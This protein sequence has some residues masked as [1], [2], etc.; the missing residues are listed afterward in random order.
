MQRSS[1]Q[2][3]AIITEAKRAIEAHAEAIDEDNCRGIFTFRKIKGEIF[4]SIKI[5]EVCN[6]P[7]L[8]HEN[9]WEERCFFP[10]EPIT[11]NLTGEYIDLFNNNK[12]IKQMATWMIEEKK[13]V[14]IRPNNSRG[15][16]NSSN[17]NIGGQHTQVFQ[18]IKTSN[19]TYKN[20]EDEADKPQNNL[21]HHK[22]RYYT[23]NLEAN[24][25]TF[26][27][28]LHDYEES[29]DEYEDTEDEYEDESEDTTEDEDEEVVY[30]G[31]PKK[32]LWGKREDVRTIII[33]PKATCN[34]IGHQLLP[35]LKQRIERATGVTPIII[36]SYAKVKLGN[37]K[38]VESSR[39]IIVPL[40]LGRTRSYAEVHIVDTEAPFIIGAEFLR[41]HRDAISV[42][43]NYMI[44]NNHRIELI[45]LPSA[46]TALN[47]DVETHNLAQ[48]HKNIA[49]Q[50][51]WAR[52]QQ[53]EKQQQQ[54]HSVHEQPPQQQ[55]QS[56][57]K[58]TKQQQEKKQPVHEQLQQQLDQQQQ[59]EDQQLQQ[60]PKEQSVQEG[61]QHQA[62]QQNM[63]TVQ[64]KT[65][66]LQEKTAQN[67]SKNNTQ[68]PNID[69]TQ[70]DLKT[71]RNKTEIKIK[72]CDEHNTT[73]PVD[74]TSRTHPS[75][76]KNNPRIEAPR[77]KFLTADNLDKIKYHHKIRTNIEIGNCDESKL[78][79]E[80]GILSKIIH[81][82]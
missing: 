66:L 49:S 75:M 33:D 25:K 24:L 34:T 5:C 20:S 4:W 18:P 53:P 11:Q 62:L 78:N 45:C 39:K 35:L 47:W 57:Y 77:E 31:D 30:T 51:Q 72:R 61:Q 42:W 37:N 7:T 12:R 48:T 32:I 1:S 41:P 58:Q 81:P 63:C 64:S 73:A 2:A 3:E 8:L 16:I 40:N 76:I 19:H 26:I 79:V 70:H 38:I 69:K 17:N 71:G 55:Q 44:V 65:T 67:G 27:Y 13:K 59:L 60:H 28:N 9:P 23:Y 50:Q 74:K 52:E 15:W 68:R 10:G 80:A 6:R 22:D 21:H 14:D 36:P 46:H 54:P 29:E 43:E 56:I 82:R